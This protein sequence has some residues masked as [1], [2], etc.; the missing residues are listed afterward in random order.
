MLHAVG[1]SWGHT[2]E[3]ITPILY[4]LDWLP[5]CFWFQCKVL[6]IIFKGLNDPQ[7]GYL[8]GLLSPF[9]S[10][11]LLLLASGI[12]LCVLHPSE[13]HPGGTCDRLF[14]SW[15][16]GFGASSPG[17]LLDPRPP[18]WGLV[19]SFLLKQAQGDRHTPHLYFCLLL[20]FS[21]C[22]VQLRFVLGFG[23][24]LRRIF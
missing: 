15:P 6:V 22:T 1:S 24:V 9:K 7:P 3:H 16:P 14:Q 4:N 2:W 12:L 17:G 21:W 20:L 19:K 11:C 8:K 18:H 5:V 10:A 23:I 13:V